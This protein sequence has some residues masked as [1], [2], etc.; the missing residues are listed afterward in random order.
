MD[1]GQ[2][3]EFD[4]MSFSFLRGDF[5]DCVEEDGLEKVQYRPESSGP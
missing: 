1:E 3:G 2:G 5:D 4:K